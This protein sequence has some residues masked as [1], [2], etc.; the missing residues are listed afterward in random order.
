MTR[1]SSPV[2]PWKSRAAGVCRARNAFSGEAVFAE[3][4]SPGPSPKTLILTYD[5]IAGGLDGSVPAHGLDDTLV[6]AHGCAPV[7]CISYCALR[8]VKAPHAK[9]SR[10]RRSYAGPG[11]PR[12]ERGWMPPGNTYLPTY[13]A[14]FGLDFLFLAFADLART[15]RC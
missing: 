7:Y 13:C 3:T 6:G 14:A 8:M 4:P 10:I 12:E 11:A 1:A 2:L 9:G 5:N 15:W